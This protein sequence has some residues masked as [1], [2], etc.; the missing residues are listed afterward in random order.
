MRRAAAFPVEAERE[1]YESEGTANG[2]V[3]ELL[4]RRPF[5]KG[6]QNHLRICLEINYSVNGIAGLDLVVPV[7]MEFVAADLDQGKFF[8]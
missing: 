3:Y 8:V 1:Q 5:F 6:C 7:A 2:D 4:A